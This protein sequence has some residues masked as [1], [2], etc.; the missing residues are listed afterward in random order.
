MPDPQALP[1]EPPALRAQPLGPT[2]IRPARPRR[3]RA[4]LIA[5]VAIL[6]SLV[7][8]ASLWFMKRP[9][10]VAVTS[11]TT[12]KEFPPETSTPQVVPAPPQ[13][14][15]QTKAQG[16]TQA[17][18]QSQAQGQAQKQAEL[19]L[20]T[21]QPDITQLEP[22]QA[23]AASE[24]QPTPAASP[25]RGKHRPPE[26]GAR[27]ARPNRDLSGVWTGVYSNATGSAALRVVHLEIRQVANGSITGSL[28]YKT[29]AEEGETCTLD[30]SSYSKEQ[31]RLRLIVHCPSPSHPRYLNVPL[32]FVG[33]DPGAN[34][35][36]GGKLEF[37]LADDIVVS[38]TRTRSA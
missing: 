22:E 31:K 25:D 21:S 11:D 17:Q 24:T 38:L 13:V 30:K 6:V 5:T 29:D 26:S 19:P 36:Q 3:P 37:H 4:T 34:S 18:G 2:T 27:P 9:S 20:N 28:T 15:V 14:Q 7:A 12:A 35:L 32:D 10:H 16:Q 1:V 23:R 33:V 8:G